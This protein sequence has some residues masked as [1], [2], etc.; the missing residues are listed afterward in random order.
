MASNVPVIIGVGDFKNRSQKVEDAFEPAELML[1]AIEI[2]LK[3]SKASDLSRLQSQ[4]DSIDVVLPWTWPYPDLA[5]LLAGRLGV[6]A[7]HK[8][9]SPHGGNQPAKLLDE[10]ARRVAK[11]HVKIAV[12]TGGEALASLSA[13]AAANKLPPPGWTKPSRNVDSVFSPTTRDLG[14]DLGARHGIGAPIQVYPLYENGFRAHRGQSLVENN[15][16][17]AE[18]YAE[19]AKVAEKQPFAWN[20]G[21]PAATAEFIGTPSKKNRMICTPYTLLMNAFNTVN[22]AGA[23]VLTSTKHAKELGVPE[24]RWIYPLGGAGTSDADHF[25][26]RPNFYHAPAISR[27]IDAAL[28]MSNLSKD[29]IDLYDFYSCFPIVPKLACEHLGLPIVGS[30]KPITLLGGLTS[31][32][33]AGNNYSMHAITEMTRQLRAGR[34]KNGLIL[35]NGGVLT[36]QYVVC[37][38]ST[39]RATPYPDRNPLPDHLANVPAPKISESPKGEAVIETY[40]VDWDRDG[41]P[42]KAHIIGRMKFSGERFVANHADEATLMALATGKKEPIGLSGVVREDSR[43]KGHN[44]FSLTDSAR[45]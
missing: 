19:W 7:Q 20:Y 8:F 21:K 35:A 39:P 33:G 38:S 26:E 5:G 44:L 24:D 14:T 13:C 12:I 10:A 17:S 32:G 34:G 42:G 37:L 41:K 3:D 6:Q 30:K 2:A 45:L 43:L 25:W 16:E 27:S 9:V 1:R 22:L 31:F 18:M 4:I 36:Y 28:Q 15:K 23:V 11:G 40:T 29:D